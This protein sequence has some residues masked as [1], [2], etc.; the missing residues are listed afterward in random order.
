MDRFRGPI[1]AAVMAMSVWLAGCLTAVAQDAP[2]SDLQTMIGQMLIVGFAGSTPEN[3]DVESLTWQ[4]DHGIIG[5]VILLKR[6]IKNPQQ[7]AALTQHLQDTAG[8]LPLFIGIDQEG[9]RVQ[10]LT[11]EA[12]FAEWASAAEVSRRAVRQPGYALGYYTARG[13]ELHALH[14]NLNFGPVVDLNVN[15]ANPVIGAL[16][17]SYSADPA[18]VTAEGGDFV[19]GHRAN[20]VLT[21]VKHFPGH[22]SSLTDSHDTLPDISKTWTAAELDPYREL[23]AS[24]L[25]DMAMVGH[26]V[27]P[28]FSDRAGVPV[29]LSAKGV[30]ALRDLVGKDTVIIT[31]DLQMGAIQQNYPEAEAA[32]LAILAGNDLLIHSTF[33]RIDPDIGPRLNLEIQEAVKSGRIPLS[34]IEEAYAR[35][36][37]LKARIGG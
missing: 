32:I 29:S 5:G 34:R 7:L 24:G 10:R 30:G 23:G 28:E 27:L 3:G 25:V 6:N 18:V 16:D 31:D 21:A 9:G 12:G 19:L 20:G 8:L 4:I 1:R 15:P 36:V 13:A 35:I 22:G 11:S 26:L 2:K 17:R 37:A 14:I 33:E